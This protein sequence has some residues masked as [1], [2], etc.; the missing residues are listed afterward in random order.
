[1][2]IRRIYIIIFF[3]ILGLYGCNNDDNTTGPDEGLPDWKLG[4]VF[5]DE[6]E[7]IECIVGDMPLVISVPHGG[8]LK[9]EEVPDRVCD[10]ITTVRDTGT[11][12]LA[13]AIRKEMQEKYGKTPYIIISHIARTKIDL[14]REIEE[15][16]CNN[17]EVIQ[18]WHDFHDF[19]ETSL[20]LSVKNHGKT[21]YIDL[22][23]HGH[24]IQ[25]L[26]LGFGLTANRL[27]KV[28]TGH[29]LQDIAEES[30]VNNLLKDNENYTVRDVLIG[31]KAFGTLMTDRGLPSVPSKQ[32]PY[33]MTN[34]TYFNG[35]FNTRLYTS[36]DF[37][38]ISGW[39]IETNTEARNSRERRA[40]FAG[41]FCESYFEFIGTFYP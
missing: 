8:D 25:R 10:G 19:V 39:Q 4:D 23:S 6:N 34:E 29:E 17:E 2:G 20:Q 18:T 38:D 40:K 36:V 5:Y 37:P 11:M 26:E 12:E 31:D 21:L 27:G 22:H 30:S 28:Y 7:W 41:A 33:P 13:E 3:G 35:G 32:D 1:M 16:T 15:A 14:N 24:T 9:P